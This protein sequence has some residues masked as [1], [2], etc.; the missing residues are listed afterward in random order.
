[1]SEVKD[2]LEAAEAARAAAR[3][4]ALQRLEELEAERKELRT[5][6]GRVRTRKAAASKPR[7]RKSQP[8]PVEAAG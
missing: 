3:V 1:M 6:L 7:A 2:A 8:A 4:R 5:L